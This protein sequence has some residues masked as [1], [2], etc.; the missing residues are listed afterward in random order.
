[1]FAICK[2]TV[3][4]G[5]ASVDGH[6]AIFQLLRKGDI[7]GEIAILDGNPRS[8]DAVA[9]TDCELLVIERRRFLAYPAK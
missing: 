6:A 1:M 7:F 4:I 3:K 8:A 9:T 2:G 5:I